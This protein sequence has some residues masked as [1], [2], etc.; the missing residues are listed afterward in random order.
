MPADNRLRNFFRQL[1]TGVARNLQRPSR[2][3]AVPEDQAEALLSRYMPKFEQ[4]VRLYTQ[5]LIEGRWKPK[6]W[7]DNVEIAI[8]NLYLTA[9]IAGA[10]HVGRLMP[11][12]LSDVTERLNSQRPFLDKFAAEVERM[13][14]AERNLDKL[15]KRLAL[16]AKPAL[17]VVHAA[18]DRTYGRPNLPFR[19]KDGTTVCMNGCKCDWV[20]E[21]VNPANGDWDVRWVLDRSGGVEHCSTCLTRAVAFNPLKIRGGVIIT[22]INVPGVRAGR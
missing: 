14:P 13:E 10:G 4:D 22:N 12:V 11:Q 18:I 21:D 1:V 19:P 2:A 8:R 9:A 7:R 3:R 15:T 5:N 20:W 6:Q 17:V 16:Y